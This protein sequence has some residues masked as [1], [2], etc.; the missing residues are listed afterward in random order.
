[1]EDGHLNPLKCVSGRA[2]NAFYIQIIYLYLYCF[3]FVSIHIVLETHT[4]ELDDQ[5]VV[6]EQSCLSRC[7]FGIDTTNHQFNMAIGDTSSMEESVVGYHQF[8]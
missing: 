8:E 7:R 2:V 1:M 6:I 3:I 4:Y 5:N